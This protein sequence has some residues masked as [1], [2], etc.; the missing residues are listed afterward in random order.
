MSVNELIDT[1]NSLQINTN[2]DSPSQTNT[3]KYP[4]I[5]KP[6]K[7]ETMAQFK[8]EY[9]SCIPEFDG[10]PNDLNRFLAVSES[11]IN[12]FYDATNHNNFQNVYLLN[13]VIS[14]LKGNAK[15]LINIQPVNTWA[16]LKALLTRNFADQR[17]EVCLN[18]DL[19]MLRQTN[20]ETPQQ[21]HD[22]ILNILNLLCSHINMHE[23]TEHAKGLK[24]TLYQN[25]ALKTFLSGLK[26]PLGTTIR[27]MRPDSLN[28]ALQF[29]LEENN[30]RYLQNQNQNQNA[31]QKNPKV[32]YI[33]QN[34]FYNKPTFQP[35]YTFP[36]NNNNYRQPFP[37]GPINI[38]P[39]TNMPQKKFFTN[40]QVFKKPNSQNVNVFKPN[41]NATFTK[42]TPM[43]IASSRN[44]TQFTQNR[45]IRPYQQQQSSRKYEVEELYNIETQDEK[46]LYPE[47][48]DNVLDDTAY[49][50]YQCT[51]PSGSDDINYDVNFPKAETSRNET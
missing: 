41:Q 32:Q 46:Q 28:Q 30:V 40:S 37:T 50:D 12:N 9:L 43:S 20:H 22:K 36:Q 19:V 26:E 25:L 31:Q 34:Q 18:R 27:C 11:I 5:H 3:L 35:Q 29:V 42:P 49:C 24:R 44:P 17:D 1:L 16:D 21:F 4:L 23:V 14:K 13:S 33:P 38:Q 45:N 15:T 8:A 51:D 7:F 10:N 6:T 47:Q 48:V 2:T 39:K